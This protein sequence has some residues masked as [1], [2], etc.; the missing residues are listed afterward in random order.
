MGAF[1]KKFKNHI[2][3]TGKTVLV[4]EDNDDLR[5]LMVSL[6]SFGGA[7]AIEARN[8]NECLDILSN[9]KIDAILIDIH[10][11]VMN[12][13]TASKIIKN[14]DKNSSVPIIVVSSD[15]EALDKFSRESVNVEGYLRKPF[16]SAHFLHKAVKVLQQN[17]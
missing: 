12:G 14:C 17:Q 4:A 2:N 10:M 6:L 9:E 5:S 1:L 13:K 3:L 7:V 16:T 15:H 8:G 11:P